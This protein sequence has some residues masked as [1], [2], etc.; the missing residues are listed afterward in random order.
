[1]ARGLHGAV[2]VEKDDPAGLAILS[3]ALA[4]LEREHIGMRYPMFAGMYARGLL[5]FGRHA[6]ALATIEEASERSDMHGEL[7]CMPELMRI[8]GDILE[9]SDQRIAETLY[10]QAIDIAR[11]QGALFHELRAAKSL[12]RLKARQGETGQARSVLSAVYEKFTE[13]FDIADLKEAR[14]MLDCWSGLP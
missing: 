14:A 5:R 6:E 13:G 12:A 2:R 4:Q 9:T 1:M 10:R 7:W 3:D 11:Q 8:Q